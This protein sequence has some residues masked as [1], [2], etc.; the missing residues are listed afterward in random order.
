[1]KEMVDIAKSTM[2]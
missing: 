2:Y 1:M